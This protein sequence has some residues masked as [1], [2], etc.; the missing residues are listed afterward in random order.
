M[1]QSPFGVPVRVPVGVPVSVGRKSFSMY[2]L[3]VGVPVFMSIPFKVMEKMKEDIHTIGRFL[4]LRF[5]GSVG[6]TVR[7]WNTGTRRRNPLRIK[8][9]WCSSLVGGRN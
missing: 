5:I 4:L 7:D 9:F 2:R 3:E 6:K 1:F 8:Q